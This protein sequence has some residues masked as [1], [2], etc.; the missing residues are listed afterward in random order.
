MDYRDN[1]RYSN[2]QKDSIPVRLDCANNDPMKRGGFGK[3]FTESQ[4]ALNDGSPGIDPQELLNLKIKYRQI[5][6]GMSD[7]HGR[8]KLDEAFN[9]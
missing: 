2:T 6:S 8:I 1:K 4:I 9:G 5:E 7:H 3:F